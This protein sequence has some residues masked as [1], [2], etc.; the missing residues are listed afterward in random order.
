MPAVPGFR[1]YSLDFP[2]FLVDGQLTVQGSDVLI[3]SGQTSGITPTHRIPPGSVVVKKTADGKYYLADD[4]ANGDRNSAPTIT[5]SGHADTLGALVI[6]GNH[7]TISVT[8]STGTGTEAENV[9]DLNADTAFA[10]HYVASSGAGELTIAARAGGAEEWFYIDATSADGFGL[11]EGDAN[12]VEGAD[13]DYRVTAFHA[14]TKDLE[15]TNIDAL[16]ANL[17]RG[18]FRESELSN[19]TGEAKAVLLRRGSEFA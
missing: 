8:T 11:A 13:A 12:K 9:T 6:V 16:A 15:G 14:D 3:A 1:S 18:K 17:T 4:A 2:A 19:L 10:A 5:S 7:G